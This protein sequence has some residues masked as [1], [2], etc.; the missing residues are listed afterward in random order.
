MVFGGGHTPHFGTS[1]FT[2]LSSL[3]NKRPDLSGRPPCK[4][5]AIGVARRGARLGGERTLRIPPSCSLPVSHA[6]GP[7]VASFVVGRSCACVCA[8]ACVRVRARKRRARKRP[9]KKRALPKRFPVARGDSAR[10]LVTGPLG[11]SGP[12]VLCRGVGNDL[13]RP[14]SLSRGCPLH[15]ADRPAFTGG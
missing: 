15:W 9:A 3:R 14:Q 7:H 8:G 4:G 5:V 13:L 2:P 11:R 6:G 12:Q 1:C 10:K